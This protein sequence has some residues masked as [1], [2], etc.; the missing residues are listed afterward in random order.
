[1]KY[2]K[3][4]NK[5][6]YYKPYN[7]LKKR[8]YLQSMRSKFKKRLTKTI[9]EVVDRNVEKKIFASVY[10]DTSVNASQMLT[11][12]LTDV[13]IGT[14]ANQRIG[15]E[16]VGDHFEILLNVYNTTNN[17]LFV[18]VSLLA[19]EA[20][21]ATTD[22]DV[23]TGIYRTPNGDV[24]NLTTAVSSAPNAAIMWPY[25]TRGTVKVLKDKVLKIPKSNGGNEGSTKTIKWYVP[26]EKKITFV[27]QGSQGEFNQSKRVTLLCTAWS[28]A[29]T[30]QSTYTYNVNGIMQ[31]FFKDQ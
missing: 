8:L 2:N 7:D 30:T 20:R 17:D 14:S 21:G 9:Q 3:R 4:Y 12:Q 13:P 29:S 19:E 16:I 28:P 1:M 24:T 22:I 27:N 15:N 5:R 18:R 10:A 25:D 26:Y 23:T 31:F 11:S 6:P